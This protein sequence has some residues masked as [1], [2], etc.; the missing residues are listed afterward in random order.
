MGQNK[1]FR[2]FIVGIDKRKMDDII[3]VNKTTCYN[4]RFSWIFEPKHGRDFHAFARQCL[5]INAKIQNLR[6]QADAAE[7]ELENIMENMSK[8]IQQKGGV[9]Y[10]GR[11][12]ER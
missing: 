5:K 10:G 1:A 12:Q 3:Y 6:R 7:K 2:K 9:H 11:G 8:S 4:M